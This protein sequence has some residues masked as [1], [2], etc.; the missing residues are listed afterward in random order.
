M[1]REYDAFEVLPDGTLIWKAEV[2]GHED[3][4]KKLKE[5][6]KDN[7]NEFRLMHV[8]S[9]TVIATINAPRD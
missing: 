8:R 6:A 3:A 4:I 2:T 7:P 9:K 1:N 5:V